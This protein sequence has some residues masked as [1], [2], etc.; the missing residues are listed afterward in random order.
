MYR[1]N[2]MHMLKFCGFK[3]MMI[4]IWYNEVENCGCNVALEES[5]MRLSNAFFFCISKKFTV[6]KFFYSFEPS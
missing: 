4:F 6:P 5:I 1:L 3:I 2:E